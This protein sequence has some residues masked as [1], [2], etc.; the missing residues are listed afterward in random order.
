MH[1]T[2]LIWYYPEEQN[3]SATRTLQQA[4]VQSVIGREGGRI[5]ETISTLQPSCTHPA[6]PSETHSDVLD[7]L[8]LQFGSTRVV[9][10]HTPCTLHEI[11]ISPFKLERSPNANQ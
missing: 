3:A 7:R 6:S 2:L 9:S 8:W 4:L 10:G 1:T 11:Y 5:P